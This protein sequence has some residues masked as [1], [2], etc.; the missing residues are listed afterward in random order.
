MV[1]YCLYNEIYVAPKSEYWRQLIPVVHR[2]A[3]F[4]SMNFNSLTDSLMTNDFPVPAWPN[5]AKLCPSK[6]ARKASC[7]FF[8]IFLFR[9]DGVYDVACLQLSYMFPY[10]LLHVSIY[11]HTFL[12]QLI[13]MLSTLKP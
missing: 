6:M 8:I 4:F 1:I 5:I 9:L 12:S 13:D 2:M 11:T 3:T 10:I 7:C